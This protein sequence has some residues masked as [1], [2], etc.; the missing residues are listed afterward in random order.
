SEQYA[1]AVEAYQQA[2]N[3]DPANAEWKSLQEKCQ[4]NVTAQANVSIPEISYFEKEK[5]LSSP[6]V[7]PGSIPT[8]PLPEHVKADRMAK[9]K[10]VLG[11]SIGTISTAIFEASVS[12]WG[13]VV[14]VSG[15]V[16]T[17]WYRRPLFLG[18]LTLAYMRNK[19]NK[20]NLQQTYPKGKLIGFQPSGQK[21]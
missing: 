10:L 5:L 2:L 19:L 21:P 4:Q 9:F 14:G 12:T 13:A 7:K 6:V 18:I 17:T 20:F 11:H 3:S 16:W 8:D 1:L 15:K